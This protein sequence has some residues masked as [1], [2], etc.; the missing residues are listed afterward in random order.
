MRTR[1][2]TFHPQIQTG[3]PNVTVIQMESMWLQPTAHNGQYVVLSKLRLSD[4]MSAR[5]LTHRHCKGQALCLTLGLLAGHLFQWFN[6]V[7]PAGPLQTMLAMGATRWLA[8]CCR[9]T[10]MCA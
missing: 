1:A 7:E 8:D 3:I 6:T 2:K 10:W 5:E 4:P 9:D